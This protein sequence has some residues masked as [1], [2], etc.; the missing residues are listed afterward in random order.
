MARWTLLSSGTR[1]RLPNFA[2]LISKPSAVRSVSS[3]P[4]A[5]ERR[6]P[7]RSDQPQDVMEGQRRD[8]TGRRQL[9][10][11]IHGPPD[12][13]Q[14]QQM[15]RWPPRSRLAQGIA[16]RH[17]VTF[18]VGVQDAGKIAHVAQLTCACRGDGDVDTQSR[19][20]PLR[21][22]CRHGSRHR[23]RSLAGTAATSPRPAKAFEREE[24]QIQPKRRRLASDKIARCRL[25]AVLHRIPDQRRAVLAGIVAK[26]G[27]KHPHG[28]VVAL[29][30]RL[31]DTAIAPQPDQDRA[32]WRPGS[33][34]AGVGRGGATPVP[35]RC[36]M[37]NPIFDRLLLRPREAAGSDEEVR[38]RAGAV[39]RQEPGEDI[40]ID[41]GECDIVQVEPDDEVSTAF[42]VGH[43]RAWHVVAQR[44]G[45]PAHG[46]SSL[47]CAHHDPRRYRVRRLDARRAQILG[48]TC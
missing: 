7:G 11:R 3:R 41:L 25:K 2:F 42:P 20:V 35:I 19:T 22:T 36:S 43:C 15:R 46:S 48:S 37:N 26:Q 21:T 47:S 12:L 10:R 23:Q 33:S 34:H 32:T 28:L 31:P 13:G 30:G 6:K 18:V 29:Y 24:A 8:R 16:V 40:V 14:R 1:R 4:V 45:E 44:P 38:M 9:Q 5:S 17:F 27:K 39:M